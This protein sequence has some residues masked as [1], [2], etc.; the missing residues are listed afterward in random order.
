[1]TCCLQVQLRCEI[2]AQLH[3][4]ME[5]QM[6]AHMEQQLCVVCQEHEKKV[7][8]L[9]CKHQCMCQQCSNQI[10]KGD[11]MCPLCRVPIQS[12]FATF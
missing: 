6:H 1:M 12:A 2:E 3:A 4:Q 11:A 10:S 9:P 7:V 8:L 5:A